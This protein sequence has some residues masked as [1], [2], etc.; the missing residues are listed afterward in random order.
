MWSDTSYA[1]LRTWKIR[2]S[3]NAVQ[4]PVE[5]ELK[6]SHLPPHSSWK[7]ACR[8]LEAAFIC[9]WSLHCGALEWANKASGS[10][11]QCR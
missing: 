7:E 8:L 3:A 11:V 6:S 2:A 1:A 9:L 5:E 4:K 10:L